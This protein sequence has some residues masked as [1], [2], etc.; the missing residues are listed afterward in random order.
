MRRILIFPN[1]GHD[2]MVSHRRL[3]FIANNWADYLRNSPVIIPASPLSE[4]KISA[5][6]AVAIKGYESFPY[7]PPPKPGF[8]KA[9]NIMITP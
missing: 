4:Q 1:C 7:L 3:Y 2:K 5:S 6:N 9:T 8:V